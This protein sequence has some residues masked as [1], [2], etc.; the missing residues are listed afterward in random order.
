MPLHLLL[1]LKLPRLLLPRIDKGVTPPHRQTLRSNHLLLCLCL[2]QLVLE[3]LH[4]LLRSLLRHLRKATRPATAANANGAISSSGRPETTSASPHVRRLQELGAPTLLAAAGTLIAAS[5]LEKV[6]RSDALA[7]RQRR[8]CAASPPSFKARVRPLSIVL[9]RAPAAPSPRLLEHAV[10][11]RRRAGR[12]RAPQPSAPDTSS[13]TSSSTSRECAT[14]LRGS[15][16][17]VTPL[18]PGITSSAP[19][20]SER[21]R[22]VASRKLANPGAPA[23]ADL[24]SD[25]LPFV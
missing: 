24:V 7:A 19:A 6:G 10:R 21:D 11:A 3:P 22:A 25:V 9:E 20:P 12:R 4:A 5:L 1:P 13:S 16:D 15:R 8:S 14:V 2:G 17:T 18:H 23:F